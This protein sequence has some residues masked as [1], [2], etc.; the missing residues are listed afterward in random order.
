[1]TSLSVNIFEDL[2]TIITKEASYN[3][4]IPDD[5]TADTNQKRSN[6]NSAL[7][8]ALKERIDSLKRQLRDK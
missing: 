7:A 8:A 2:D 5:F 6:I 4:D 1:M 3:T